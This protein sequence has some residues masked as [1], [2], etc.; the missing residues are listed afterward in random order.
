MKKFFIRAWLVGSALALFNFV[1][2]GIGVVL[3]DN[4]EQNPFDKMFIG[5]GI[6]I[7]I[8]LFTAAVAAATETW[9]QK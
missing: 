9:K 2:G 7:L 3:H 6:A 5:G 8:L 1:A 4:P